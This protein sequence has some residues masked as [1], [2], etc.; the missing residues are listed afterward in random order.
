MEVLVVVEV[1]RLSHSACGKVN[2]VLS[3][4]ADGEVAGCLS[5]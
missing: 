3:L 2:V 4:V 5:S 1:C